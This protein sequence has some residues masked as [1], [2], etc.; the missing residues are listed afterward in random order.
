MKISM[1]SFN[2]TTKQTYFLSYLYIYTFSEI[3]ASFL[4]V[5]V[6]CFAIRNSLVG[7]EGGCS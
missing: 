6:D 3:H 5:S 2:K 4:V 7:F 1:A